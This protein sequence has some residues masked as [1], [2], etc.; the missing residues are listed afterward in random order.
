MQRRCDALLLVYEASRSERPV[1]LVLLMGLQSEPKRRAG[2]ALLATNIC[3]SMYRGRTSFGLQKIVLQ[4]QSHVTT[5]ATSG[6]G[7]N[8]LGWLSCAAG[9]LFDSSKQHVGIKRLRQKGAGARR[10]AMFA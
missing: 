3:R 2:P 9:G 10:L 1:S 4:L 8:W 7:G 5:C 6:R